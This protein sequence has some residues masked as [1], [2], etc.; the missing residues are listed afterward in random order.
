MAQLLSYCVSRRSAR[1]TIWQLVWN[2]EHM[3]FDQHNLAVDNLEGFRA[4]H[5]SCILV[6][7]AAYRHV[8][9][10]PNMH[11]LYGTGRVEADEVKHD[12]TLDIGH[13]MAPWPYRVGHAPERKLLADVQRAE[14]H[15]PFRAR[16]DEPARLTAGRRHTVLE[17]AGIVGEWYILASVLLDAV[18]IAVCD[19]LELFA[20]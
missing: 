14:I 20:T 19:L 12:A 2:I 17:S 8:A 10:A 5:A 9:D 18:E 15:G 7:V 16:H 11:A 13:R 3:G 6:L 1:P 4:L